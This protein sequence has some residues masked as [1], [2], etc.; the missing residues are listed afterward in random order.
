MIAS[1][2]KWL[3]FE[4]G[5]FRARDVFHVIKIARK[6]SLG[7]PSGAEFMGGPGGG[8]TGPPFLGGGPQVVHSR[9]PFITI[10]SL[11]FY[12][13]LGKVHL[14]SFYHNF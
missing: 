10:I 1:D 14:N 2:G 5:K 6:S 12:Y 8:D 11:L 3:I 7:L 9:P 13:Y 4:T